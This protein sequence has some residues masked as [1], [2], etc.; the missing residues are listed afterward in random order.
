MSETIL[1]ICAHCGTKNRIAARHL[2]DRGRCGACK[3]DLPPSAEPINVDQSSFDTIIREARVPV[4]VDFWAAWCG[5]CRM[6]A[7]EVQALASEMAGRALVLKVDTEAVPEL[8]ARY[9]VQSIPT[10]VV[11]RDG[12]ASFQQAGLVPRTQMRQWL[13]SAGQASSASR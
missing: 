12:Q 8:A 11:F 10:F 2:A 9:R 7:P 5:P 4:L 3:A 13:E 6:A 1:R